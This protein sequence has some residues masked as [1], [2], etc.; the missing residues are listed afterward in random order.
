MG[1]Y[2]LVSTNIK[3]KPLFTKNY[4]K[5]SLFHKNWAIGQKIGVLDNPCYVFK[6]LKKLPLGLLFCVLKMYFEQK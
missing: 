1:Y 2:S 4:P 6:K 5:H 3:P